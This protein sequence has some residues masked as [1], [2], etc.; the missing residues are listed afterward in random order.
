MLPCGPGTPNQ[1]WVPNMPTVPTLQPRD[2][3]S[4]AGDAS[5]FWLSTVDLQAAACNSAQPSSMDMPWAL[6]WHEVETLNRPS[7]A[8]KSVGQ[9]MPQFVRFLCHGG[10]DMDPSFCSWFFLQG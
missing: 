10:V 8:Q 2:Y 5:C 6:S 9:W 4:M 3:T 7:C 1:S